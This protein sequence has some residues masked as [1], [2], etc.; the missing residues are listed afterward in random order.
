MTTLEG[1][2]QVRCMR[3]SVVL[4]FW[5]R[6]APL[7]K[8]EGS[9]ELMDWRPAFSGR[10]G[11]YIWHTGS[12]AL[13]VAAGC[14]PWCP[15][16]MPQFIFPSRLD[17]LILA[18]ST[19]LTTV[20][21]SRLSCRSSHDHLRHWP[22]GMVDLPMQLLGVRAARSFSGCRLRASSI[23]PHVL[24]LGLSYA[25]RTSPAARTAV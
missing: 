11:P 19:M 23:G 15:G 12:S 5:A 3:I 4:G 17:E 2:R 6:W 9:G 25:S 14:Q 18:A 7:Q 10:S 16:G 22:E 8:L 13:A 24:V 21:N 1:W 20:L